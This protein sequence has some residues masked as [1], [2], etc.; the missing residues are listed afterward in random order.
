[1]KAKTRKRHKLMKTKNIAFTIILFLLSCVAFTF[2]AQATP[3][4]L[5]V[6]VVNTPDV[7]V[8]NTA[9]VRDVDNA[10]RRSFTAVN[11]G[12]LYP[13]FDHATLDLATVP[14][15]KRLVVEQVSVSHTL[16][17]VAQIKLSAGVETT[18]GGVTTQYFF[19]RADAGGFSDGGFALE[20]FIASSQMRSYADAGTT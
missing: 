12:V 3:S 15:G 20:Q 14:Q 19:T 4:A 18:T 9:S 11:G 10:A 2:T 1:M 7:N 16:S 13:D 17:T 5:N 6:N 8:V